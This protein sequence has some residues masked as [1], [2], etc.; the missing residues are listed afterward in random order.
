VRDPVKETV[1]KVVDMGGAPEQP[2]ADGKGTIYDN[3]RR[4]KRVAVIDRK[5]LTIKGRWPVRLR[6]RRWL[7]IWTV[8]TDGYFRAAAIRNS[9]S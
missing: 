7:G 6:E 1:V 4:E 3:N 5:T 2:I 8:S 9:W